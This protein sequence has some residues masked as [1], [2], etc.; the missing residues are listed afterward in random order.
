MWTNKGSVS[1]ITTTVEDIDG[2]GDMEIAIGTS[3][4]FNVI[5]FHHDGTLFSGW[6][7]GFYD[8]DLTVNPSSFGDVD[9]DGDL[10]IGMGALNSFWLWHHD[11]ASVSGW[12]V[13]IPNFYPNSSVKV[14]TP[15]VYADLDKDGD[16][17]IIFG[18]RG[19]NKGDNVN[20]GDRNIFRNNGFVYVFNH[21]GTLFDYNK[22]GKPEWPFKNTTACSVSEN[23]RVCYTNYLNQVSGPGPFSRP[24]EQ[25]AVGDIEGDGIAE[26][27]FITGIFEKS[28][29]WSDY[30]KEKDVFNNINVKDVWGYRLIYALKPDGI[31][32]PGFPVY[33][34]SGSSTGPDM[35]LADME[36]DGKLEIIEKSGG[37]WGGMSVVDYKGVIKSKWKILENS[38]KQNAPLILDVNKE[39][40]MDILTECKEYTLCAYEYPGCS[41]RN[42]TISLPK[43]PVAPNSTEII[44]N[45][46]LT[47]SIIDLDLDGKM[48]LVFVTSGNV[49]HNGI[50]VSTSFL[51]VYEL[52]VPY[53]KKKIEWDQAYSNI[54]NTG[55]YKDNL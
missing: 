40:C 52:N 17:E 13:K 43:I 50:S 24:V 53:D 41:G 10:E 33:V 16:L 30:I 42:T 51:N 49:N 37:Y 18:T 26:I 9:K 1:S 28:S 19:S 34:L 6:P 45:N 29:G 44:L 25:L 48:D 32:L 35:A 20:S 15:A 22:D 46:L 7:K 12:P 39:G 2:D 5:V 8:F 11:G 54:R 47:P 27:V 23:E 14:N 4:M 36:G 38:I 21:D 3:Y 55:V 31:I